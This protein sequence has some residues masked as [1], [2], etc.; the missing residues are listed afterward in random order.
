M[1]YNHLA[2]LTYP[3]SIKPS[4]VQIM[5]TI[6]K[7]L[8]AITLSASMIIMSLLS[9]SVQA[10]MLTSEEAISL[11]NKAQIIERISSKEV[12]EKLI[13]MGVNTD[14][15]K[16]RIDNLSQDELNTLN[17]QMDQLPAGS[18]GLGVV[19]FIFVVLVITDMI[20]ATDVFPFVDPV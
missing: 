7:K 8:T 14:N 5:K 19:V 9:T 1:R 15:L 18:G 6:F 2:R 12:S 13:A 20:G 16:T 10:K 17:N 4:G 3:L 11:Q